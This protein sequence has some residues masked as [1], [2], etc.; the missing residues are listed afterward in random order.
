[1]PIFVRTKSPAL[2]LVS[3]G[4]LDKKTL[5]KFKKEIG[6]YLTL[7]DFKMNKPMYVPTLQHSNIVY[8]TTITED[9][10]TQME[11]DKEKTEN[12]QEK[13]RIVRPEFKGYI[14]SKGGKRRR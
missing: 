11:T 8:F 14:P 12:E 5:K 6:H 9:D 13:S 7:Q 10:F 4:K 2:S 3:H 1:M